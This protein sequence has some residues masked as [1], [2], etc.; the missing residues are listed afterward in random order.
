L[1]NALVWGK[2]PTNQNAN[3]TTINSGNTVV[4]VQIPT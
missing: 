4:W 2:I 3:W 1:G